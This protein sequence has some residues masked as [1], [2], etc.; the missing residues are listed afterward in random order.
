[1]GGKTLRKQLAA[2]RVVEKPSPAQELWDQP[3]RPRALHLF[4]LT[5]RLGAT[6]RQ[7]EAVVDRPWPALPLWARKGLKR[8][9]TRRQRQ[10][11]SEE[12]EYYGSQTPPA[13]AQVATD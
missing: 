9:T 5:N 4:L 11:T 6:R 2:S 3:D 1:M 7:A 8:L 10:M 12:A 13:E